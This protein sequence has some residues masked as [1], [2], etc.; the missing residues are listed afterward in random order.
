MGERGKRG[1]GGGAGAAANHAHY[2][3]QQ[4]CKL[5]GLNEQS[6]SILKAQANQPQILEAQ[7]GGYGEI[8]SS[9]GG[10][11]SSKGAAQSRTVIESCG[12]AAFKAVQKLDWVYGGLRLQR[13]GGGRISKCMG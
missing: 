10:G 12:A 3:G 6:A 5:H 7:R 8:E 4:G 1:E 9:E 2:A 13:Q 11:S